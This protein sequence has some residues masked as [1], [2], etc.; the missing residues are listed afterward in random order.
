MAKAINLIGKR[1]GKLTAIKKGISDKNCLKWVCRCDCGRVLEINGVILRKGGR[2]DC[3]CV[4]PMPS[5]TH[6]GDKYGMLTVVRK[7]GSNESGRVI[8]ECRCDCGNLTTAF[9]KY[10]HQAKNP[11]CGCYS[12]SGKKKIEQLCWECKHATNAYGACQ[13][14]ASLK[15]VNGWTAERIK[16]NGAETY[17]IKACPLFE[18][19]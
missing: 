6:I 12:R 8:W 3:G 2:T 4:K 14:S 15:P 1:F 17:T 13:W 7:I 11:N 9:T 10:L 19:G 5:V 16:Y 18:R